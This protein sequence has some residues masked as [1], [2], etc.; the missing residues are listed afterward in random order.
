MQQVCGHHGKHKPLTFSQGSNIKNSDG[1][2]VI[3]SADWEGRLAQVVLD[4]R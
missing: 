1:K 4:K 2:K 3:G